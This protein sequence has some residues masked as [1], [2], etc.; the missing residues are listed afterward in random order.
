[1]QCLLWQAVFC[2]ISFI[3]ALHGN[4]RAQLLMYTS[5]VHRLSLR[6]DSHWDQEPEFNSG[7]RR[8]MPT[9]LNL[10]K[11]VPTWIIRQDDRHG[12]IFNFRIINQNGFGVYMWRSHKAL[13]KS[14]PWSQKVSELHLY[15]LWY[16]T[17][18]RVPRDATVSLMQSL[19]ARYRALFLVG[20]TH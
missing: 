2:S 14:N 1:M 16:H 6:L 7:S 19:V 20:K 4:V 18:E 10:Q 17:L 15:L 5:T 8:P 3:W 9:T 12:G 13:L 11:Q